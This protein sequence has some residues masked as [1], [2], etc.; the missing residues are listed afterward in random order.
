MCNNEVIWLTS[1]PWL[2]KCCLVASSM[3]LWILGVGY[4][5]RNERAGAAGETR[6][7]TVSFLFVLWFSGVFIPVRLC[8]GLKFVFWSIEDVIGW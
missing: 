4:E 1:F 3:G 2:K 8:P 7:L 5:E 6:V